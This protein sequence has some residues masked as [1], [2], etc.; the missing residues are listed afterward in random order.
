MKKILLIVLSLMIVGCNSSK[1]S[2]DVTQKQL[3]IYKN[4]LEYIKNK[5]NLVDNCDIANSE[6]YYTE[7]KSGY[8]YDLVLDK[9][10]QVLY[11]IRVI[12]YTDSCLDDYQPNIGYFDKESYTLSPYKTDKKR[13]IYKGISLSGR[14]KR[15]CP[16]KVLITY[17][18][19]AKMKKKHRY[20]FE[21]KNEN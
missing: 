3:E 21:V 19:D 13:F 9:T 14:V 12:T 16:I 7:I 10:S 4:D 17:Y 1:N 18:D 2:S 15:K 8:R 6:L 5:D 11:N 20:C